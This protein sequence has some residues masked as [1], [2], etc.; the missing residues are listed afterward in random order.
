M[1]G[2][3]DHDHADREDQHV[4]VLLD[5]VV[6][7]A[8]HQQAAAGQHLEQQDDDDEGGEDAVLADVDVAPFL[9]GPVGRS[10]RRPWTART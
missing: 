6:D 5:Q 9:L 2:D 7:V 10:D 1:A 3:D 8:G 4:R